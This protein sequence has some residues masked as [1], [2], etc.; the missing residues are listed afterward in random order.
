LVGA[1]VDATQASSLFEPLILG[2]GRRHKFLGLLVDELDGLFRAGSHAKST[3]NALLADDPVGIITLSDSLHLTT[4][5]RT[6][7]TNGA[8]VWIDLSVVVRIDDNGSG[9][10]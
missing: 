9:Y 4:F 8:F 10:T 2:K 5:I 3:P 6:D 7:S 1:E